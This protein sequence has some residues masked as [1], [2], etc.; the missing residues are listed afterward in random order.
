M[1][2]LELILCV[3]FMGVLVMAVYFIDT[4]LTLKRAP[5]QPA[6]ILGC[7]LLWPALAAVLLIETLWFTPKE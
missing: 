3:Y 5:V 4:W 7:V 1:A 2:G 6:L